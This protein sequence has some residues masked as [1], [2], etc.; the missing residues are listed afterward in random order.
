MAM[1]LCLYIMAEK[2]FFTR[3]TVFRSSAMTQ[4]DGHGGKTFT[5][6]AI[7]CNGISSCPANPKRAARH[8]HNY[9]HADP[10]A[11]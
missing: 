11:A 8:T 9:F 4:I 5:V 2:I 7:F 10:P 1:G 3:C 6:A